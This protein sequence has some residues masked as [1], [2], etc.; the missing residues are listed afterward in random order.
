M[1]HKLRK[2]LAM[3]MTLCMIIST[4]ATGAAATDTTTAPF[5]DIAGHWAEDTITRWADVGIVN[6]YPDGTFRPDEPITRAELAKIVTLAFGLTEKTEQTFA[7][8]DPA[9]W[10]Y[11]YVICA[12]DYINCLPMPLMPDEYN[13]YNDNNKG[14]MVAFYPEEPTLRY[15]AAETFSLM[16]IIR[17]GGYKAEYPDEW[18]PFST[19][20]VPHTDIEITFPSTFEIHPLLKAKY[21]DYDL[22]SQVMVVGDK[23]LQVASYQE[24]GLRYIWLA[25]RLGIMQGEQHYDGLYFLPFDALPRA[26]VL[27]LLDRIITPGA[28]LTAP[29]TAPTDT[30][31]DRPINRAELARLVTIAFDLDGE[32]ASPLY[33]C[34]PD[35]WYYDYVKI[36]AD[37]IPSFAY[38]TIND[39]SS[40]YSQHGNSG[41]PEISSKYF[42]PYSPVRRYHVAATF[43]RLK[44]LHDGT[45]LEIPENPMDI[46]N[47][48]ASS[49]MDEE[50]QSLNTKYP[51]GS[52][53]SNLPY[54]YRD[55]QNAIYSAVMLGVMDGEVGA[56]GQN[57]FN[58]LDSLTFGDAID[59]IRRILTSDEMLQFLIELEQLGVDVT[60]PG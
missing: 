43:S 6:G 8:L 40:M 1:N 14:E 13:Y 32:T 17:D 5:T 28:L 16:K 38:F 33:D 50:L 49:F 39:L 45:T 12:S 44:L 26:E 18:E 46:Y 53:S 54:A 48:I 9:A 57:Y 24:R 19:I 7:D 15:Q 23:Q 31:P 21:L 29:K 55:S 41:N 58:S 4:L 37:Y 51:V 56:D 36:A 42:M 34:E 47:V 52:V 11:D 27:T 30:N 35:A 25:D 3:V 10:Y 2:L 20:V 59:I 22:G 60:V